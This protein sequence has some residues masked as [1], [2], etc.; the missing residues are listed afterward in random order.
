MNSLP[1]SGHD[2]RQTPVAAVGRRKAEPSYRREHRADGRWRAARYTPK[3]ISLRN[4][5]QHVAG[6]LMSKA[7]VQG[8][9]ADA[10]LIQSTGRFRSPCKVA[11]SGESPTKISQDLERL[12][13]PDPEL[14]KRP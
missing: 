11:G 2:G 8:R 5:P 7:R 13:R 9:C 10:S 6:D 1:D 4:F 12:R 3:K 14:V